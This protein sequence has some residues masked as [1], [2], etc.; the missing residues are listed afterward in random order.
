MKITH[1][2]EMFVTYYLLRPFLHTFLM[3]WRFALYLF[4]HEKYGA[5]LIAYLCTSIFAPFIWVDEFHLWII[6]L[7]DLCES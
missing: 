3:N 6:S 5:C 4:V 7:F 2:V 1:R